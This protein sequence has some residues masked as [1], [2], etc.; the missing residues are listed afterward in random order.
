[1]TTA[2]YILDVVE[3]MKIIAKDDPFV[4]TVEGGA[5]SVP[6]RFN[7]RLIC[8]GG[9]ELTV[10]FSFDRVPA[11]GKCADHL[12]M[13]GLVS[14]PVPGDIQLKVLDLFFGAEA[15]LA[16]TYRISGAVSHHWVIW[17]GL[18]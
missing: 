9:F 4:L 18:E 11:L 1:M 7:T 5:I 10:T 6:K 3:E 15:R 2:Q 8:I 13:R 16:Q 12:S 14:H 17:R